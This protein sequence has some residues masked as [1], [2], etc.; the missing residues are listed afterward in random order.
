MRS[1]LLWE[2]FSPNA[3]RPS[4]IRYA[5]LGRYRWVCQF[6]HE[7]DVLDAACGTGYG[8]ELIARHDAISVVGLDSSDEAVTEARKRCEGL[9]HVTIDRADVSDLRLSSAS[10]D[11]YVSFETIEHVNVVDCMLR[12]ARRVLRSQ[13]VF[14]CSTPNRD[15]SNPGTQLNSKPINTHHIREYSLEEYDQLLHSYFTYVEWYGQTYYSVQYVATLGAL[16][17]TLPSIAARFHQIRK[18]PRLIFTRES[19]YYPRRL[20]TQYVPETLIAV[21]SAS[22]NG[23]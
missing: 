22:V 3:W 23:D 2:R 16:G 20:Q 8:T 9:S 7:K 10:L 6:T 11:V 1:L 19:I 4:W 21:C 13:G 5:N 15:V 14:I 17:R 12:E 18:L